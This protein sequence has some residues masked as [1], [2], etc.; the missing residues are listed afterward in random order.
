MA[1]IKTPPADNVLA[2]FSGQTLDVSAISNRI[3]VPETEVRLALADPD[4]V[5]KMMRERH[6]SLDSA[7]FLLVANAQAQR[8]KD[9]VV[10]LS[11]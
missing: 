9:S 1:A 11:A 8:R 6:L 3:G 10:T 5:Q 2:G 4:T 7:V